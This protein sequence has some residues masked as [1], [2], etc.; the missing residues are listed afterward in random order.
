MSKGEEREE[1]SKGEEPPLAGFLARGWHARA[2]RR[3]E[4]GE[5][6][7][8]KEGPSQGVGRQVKGV[9]KEEREKEILDRGTYSKGVRLPQDTELSVPNEQPA[10]ASGHVLPTRLASGR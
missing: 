7:E 9:P 2:S 3:A 10:M 1:R 8:M 6:K 5:L 4:G